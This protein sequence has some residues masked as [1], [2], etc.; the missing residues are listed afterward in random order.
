MDQRAR[1]NELLLFA[2]LA[3]VAMLFAGFT[4]AYAIR[5]SGADWQP[6]ALPN[7]VWVNTGVLLASSVTIELRRRGLE[8]RWLGATIAL[9]VCFLAGQMLAWR[10]LTAQGIF[11]PTHPHSAFYY[12][13]TAVHGVHLIGGIAALAYATAHAGA[14]RLCATYWHFVGALWL[15]LFAVLTTF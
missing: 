14:V 10:A 2:I 7:I 13:L 6:V 1:A 3:T 5:R 12:L 15:Y 11:L 4:A 8:R 9:G